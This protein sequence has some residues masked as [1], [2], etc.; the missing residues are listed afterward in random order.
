MA[1]MTS[2]KAID[3]PKKINKSIKLDKRLKVI[4]KLSSLKMSFENSVKYQVSFVL[5][6][7]KMIISHVDDGEII[8]F[9][10]PS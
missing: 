8:A 10:I 1:K 5:R 3:K 6:I 7:T 4:R 9:Q 2:Y